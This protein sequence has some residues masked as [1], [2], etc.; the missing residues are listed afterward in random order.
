[1]T[2]PRVGDAF[3]GML[4]AFWDGLRAGQRTPGVLEII[5]RD[6]GFIYAV[7]PDRYFASP[8]GWREFE[9]AAL[10]LASGSVLDVGC[11]AGRF[12]LALA[13]RGVPVTALD[14]SAGALAVCRER[15]VSDLVCG[16]VCD[17]PA[18]RGYDTFLLMGENLGLLESA[19]RAAGFLGELAAIARPGARIIAH[20]ADPYAVLASDPELAA[21]LRRSREP[22]A[23]PGELTIRLRHR[24]LATSWFGYLLCSPDELASLAAPTAWELTRTDYA[25]KAN[26]LAVLSLL[27][28]ARCGLVRMLAANWANG[29]VDTP[30]SNNCT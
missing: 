16:T 23:L 14:P 3:G 9:R 2:G 7:R 18:G 12:A 5:E 15:G 22:E 19:R 11:G 29:A 24:D 30:F 10:D 28:L 13:E 25:D 6:D 8:D 20:G 27:R 17:V 1:M 4:R 26:Y 21:H